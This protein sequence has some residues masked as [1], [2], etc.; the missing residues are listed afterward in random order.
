MEHGEHNKLLEG[1]EW[2]VEDSL[3]C[4][5]SDG[6]CIS[7]RTGAGGGDTNDDVSFLSAMS[8]SKSK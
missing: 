1:S 6:N 8:L 4:V 5:R 2:L 7:F 3:T